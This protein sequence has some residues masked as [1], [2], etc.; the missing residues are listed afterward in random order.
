MIRATRLLLLLAVLVPVAAGA[1]TLN[2]SDAEYLG[3]LSQKGTQMI[4][5]IRESEDAVSRT[6][7]NHAG[8]PSVYCL[9][10]LRTDMGMITLEGDHLQSVVA[11]ARQMV[12]PTDEEIVLRFA[13]ITA[14]AALRN[15]QPLRNDVNA[16]T[17]LCPAGPLISSKVTQ[18]LSFMDEFTDVVD[19]IARRTK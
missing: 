16:I 17:G 7:P 13:K 5:D 9:E 2:N 12:N 3:V 1:M 14:E 8:V 15:I 18:I 11:I 10:K 6:V 19:A 4:A